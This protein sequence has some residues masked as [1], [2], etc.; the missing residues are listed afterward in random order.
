MI[1]HCVVFPGVQIS[2]AFL[3]LLMVSVPHIAEAQTFTMD[4]NE[5]FENTSF[6]YFINYEIIKE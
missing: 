3:T 5:V 2:Q 6:D 1:I 4:S